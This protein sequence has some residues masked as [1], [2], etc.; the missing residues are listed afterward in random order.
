[1]LPIFLTEIFNLTP[2]DAGFRTAGFVALATAMRPVGG[3]LADRVGGRRI[4]LG[5]FP[6][7]AVMGG[8]LAWPLMVTFTIGA[9][10]MC[11]AIGVGNGAVSKLVPNHFPKSVGA[12]TGL[13]GAAGG[14][15][16]FFPPLVLG[17]VRQ[18]TGT[19]TLGFVFLALFAIICF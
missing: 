18:A 8:F 11:A 19:F 4:L 16:G 17:A 1:Y 14:F 6:A 3:M 2:G 10:G 13:V 15:G 7:T 5:I 12:V 9:L